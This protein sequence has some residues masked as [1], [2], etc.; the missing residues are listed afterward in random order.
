VDYFI[1]LVKASSLPRFLP[2]LALATVLLGPASAPAQDAVVLKTGVT[3]EGKITGAK[4]GSV[5]LQMGAATTGIPVADIVEIRMAA[6]PEFDAAA[7]QLARGDAKGAVAA[8]QKI[9]TDYAGLPTAWAERATAMLGDAKLAAGDAAGAKEAY[10][11]FSRTYPKATALANLGLAR[12]AVD[13]GQYEQAGKL[14]DPVLAKSAATAF[15]EPADGP[16]LCQ[17]HYLM[18][19]VREA[20]GDKQAA[21]EH[22]LTAS[23]VFPFD[24]SAAAEAKTRADKLRSENT[25]LI[26]P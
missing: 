16:P 18:G 4:D 10:A 17:G 22:Y 11:A 23:A 25:G 24:R 13:A 12:L 15:P 19:R 20:A 9:N 6:P 5:R 21:L 7:A 8:L 26:A 3:R 14:L 2:V 1:N